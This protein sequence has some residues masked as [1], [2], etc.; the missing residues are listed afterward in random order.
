MS[1][2]VKEL[3]PEQAPEQVRPAP[4][5]APVPAPAAA[6]TRP[7]LRDAVVWAEILGKPRA[8]RRK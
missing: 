5:P 1:A 4:A 3:R 2:P 8:L 6:K 7:N